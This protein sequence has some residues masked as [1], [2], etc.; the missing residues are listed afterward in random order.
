MQ[1]DEEGFLYPQINEK[2]CINC[3]VCEKVCSIMR[4]APEPI[5]KKPK[6]YAAINTDETVRQESSSGGIFTLLAVQTIHKDGIVFGAAMTE[7][8]RSVH[9]VGIETEAGL[10]VLRGSK[11]LQ[12]EIGDTYLQARDALQAGREVLFSGTPLSD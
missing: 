12:S 6:T 11:Y 5:N 10:E 2:A 4:S 7:N 3:G 8:Q 9:H 1:A